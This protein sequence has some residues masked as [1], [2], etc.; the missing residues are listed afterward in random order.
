[1]RLSKWLALFLGCALLLSGCMGQSPSVPGQQAA[2]PASSSPASVLPASSAPQSA[3]ALPQPWEEAGS[4]NT[5]TGSTL[6]V[7]I[8]LSDAQSQWDSQSRTNAMQLLEE[9]LGYLTEEAARYGQEIR[10]AQ[11]DKLSSYYLTYDQV[12]EDSLESYWWTDE[13]LLQNGFSDFSQLLLDAQQQAGEEYDNLAAVVHLNTPGRSYALPFHE[14]NE[15]KYRAEHLVMHYDEDQSHL[16]YICAATYAHELLHLFGAR[17]LYE[18][19]G[20]NTAVE[21]AAQTVCGDSIML[22][23]STDLYSRRVDALTAYL[24]GWLSQLP[25]EF[26]PLQEELTKAYSQDTASSGAAGD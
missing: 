3:S 17:D 8:F 4:A 20:R 25:E 21:E 5:L 26:V 24:V 10:L 6:L 22:G 11:T 14:G 15:A 1:M 16:Y 12:V 9:A 2:P 13:M 19:D 23:I 7:N 18:L